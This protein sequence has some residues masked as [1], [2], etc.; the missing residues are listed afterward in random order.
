MRD[1]T[2][3]GFMKNLKA[4]REVLDFFSDEE[5]YNMKM[6]VL[7]TITLKLKNESDLIRK[8][9][10]FDFHCHCLARY[11]GPEVRLYGKYGEA[12]GD[13]EELKEALEKSDDPKLADQNLFVVPANVHT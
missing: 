7:A 12:L 2:R 1:A 6:G 11:E 13:P 10:S 9:N 3:H 4:V 8:F 5:L